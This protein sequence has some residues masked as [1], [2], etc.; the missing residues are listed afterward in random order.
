ME[1][2]DDKTS[3]L[4]ADSSYLG[5]SPVLLAELRLRDPHEALD[6]FWYWYPESR[7]FSR[8]LGDVRTAPSLETAEATGEAF[9]RY[10]GELRVL[11]GV[12]P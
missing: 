12:E 10:L 5:Q 2:P 1:Y 11:L 4:W 8:W 6:R 7:V 9:L 3:T